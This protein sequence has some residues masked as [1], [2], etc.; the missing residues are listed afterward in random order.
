MATCNKPGA[1]LIKGNSRYIQMALAKFHSGFLRVQ[2]HML[3]IKVFLLYLKCNI[4]HAAPEHILTCIECQKNQLFSSSGE[5]LITL[6][7]HQFMDL[8]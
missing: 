3:G 6:K 8:I 4:I 1:A 2:C 5:V 7:L